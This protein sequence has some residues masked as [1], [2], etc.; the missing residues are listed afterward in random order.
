MNT[1][2]NGKTLQKWHSRAEKEENME[3]SEAW[4]K[5]RKESNNEQTTSFFSNLVCEKKS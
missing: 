3:S 5:W 4:V 2:T 1:K